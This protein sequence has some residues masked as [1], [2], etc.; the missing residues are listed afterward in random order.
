M[1]TILGRVGRDQSYQNFNYGRLATSCNGQ[2]RAV[3][4]Q[5]CNLTAQVAVIGDLE[6]TGTI[7][8]GSLGQR[9]IGYVDLENGDDST[10]EIGTLNPFRTI[11]AFIDAV[12][13]GNTSESARNVFTAI[14]APGDY[15]EDLNIDV[16][17]RRI[18]L[19]GFGPWGLGTF[20]A[21][22]W[23][24]SGIRRNV[25]I[26]KTAGA[27]TDGIRPALVI[28]AY[29]DSVGEAMTT[30]QSYT[31]KPRISGMIDMSGVSTSG[32]I[33]LVLACEVFG[34][35]GV[36]I[37]GGTATVQSYMS[38]CRF[39]G[40]IGGVN[41]N[42]QISERVR[43]DGLV[44]CTGYSLIRSC[45]IN[46]GLTTTSAPPAGLEPHGIISSYFA[47]AF[48]SGAAGSLVMDGNTNFFF[49]STGATPVGA[50]AVKVIADDLVP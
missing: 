22:D 28:S 4:I 35:S 48:T 17:N 26:T 45:R 13:F 44:T 38:D 31:T 32:S 16:S 39:R 41:W 50:N 25:N 30:H 8:G 36:A 10:G 5:T 49:K 9:N 24:P 18:I 19:T 15:D 33:E 40:S 27:P 3:N 37:D 21:V 7:N 47:G 29:L 23:G 20:Q 2:I 11:Q 14:I 12:P 43:F 34:V 46:A 42:L 1:D 6:I